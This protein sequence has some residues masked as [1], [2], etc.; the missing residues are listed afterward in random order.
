MNYAVLRMAILGSRSSFGRL[1]GIVGGT[2]VGVCLLLLLWSGANGLA[3]RDDRGAWLRET[4]QPSAVAGPSGDASSPTPPVPVQLTVGTVL[5]EPNGTEIFRD[6]LIERRDVAALAGTTV[7]IPGVGTPP[8]PGDY[9]ASPALQHLIDITPGDELGSRFGKFAGF[10]DDSALPGPDSLVVVRGAT[11]AELR[12]NGR[13]FLISDFTRNPYGGSAA[14]Y[15]TVLCVGALAVLFPVLLL[16]SIVTGLGAA[17]RRERYATLRVIGASP[18]VVATIAAVET[19]VPSLIGAAVGT[20]LAVALRPA[21]ALIPVNGS[22]MFVSDLSTGWMAAVV[23]VV[24]VVVASA[25]VAGHRTLRA[26]IGPLGVTRA[27]HEKRPAVWRAVPVTAGLAA[28][29]AAIL[30]DRSGD[31]VLIRVSSPL[32]I[33]GFFLVLAGIVAIGPWLTRLV[34][35]LALKGAR[36][37][38]GVIAAGRIQRTPVAT[39][40]S[41]SGLVVAVFVVSVFAGGASVVASPQTPPARPGLMQPSSLSA[42]IATGAKPDQVVETVRRAEETSGIKSAVIGYGPAALSERGAA[43]EIYFP[44]GDAAA[45]G[46]REI[47]AVD[48]V[49]VDQSFLYSWTA[50]PLT[51]TAA[52]AGTLD[53]LVPVGVVIATDGTPAAVDRARTV[54]NTSGV[55]AA[56]AES[57]SDITLRSSGRL[58]QGLAALAYLGMFVSIVIAGISLAVA[59]A[60]AMLDRRRVLGLMRLMG[61]PASVLRRVIAREAAVP[62]LTVVLLSVTLGFVVAWLM[63]TYLDD[64]YRLTWPAPEYFIVLGLSLVLALGA[65]VA[66]FG[67]TGR[68]TALQSTRFE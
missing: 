2:A 18:R 40:R 53:G 28:L 9:V 49:A 39:F 36:T 22:K 41:V 15:N 26:G 4:G 8:E 58:I 14:A 29:T 37:A 46:F 48:T 61:M 43:R 57:P 7:G 54:L 23:V 16:I 55:T 68:S 51:L 42:T 65:V 19:A 25:F 27:V 12:Q 44:A 5:V 6:H 3:A 62:L 50:Q 38:D 66:T 60:S 32:L 67:L 34:S 31:A 47:P 56:P 63:V 21:A 1:A 20:V 11:E 52:P 35:G 33:L 45:L 13:A 30:A 10:I 24:V 17:Q 59:T 64:S